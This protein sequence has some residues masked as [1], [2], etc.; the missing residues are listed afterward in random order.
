MIDKSIFNAACIRRAK[1]IFLYFLSFFQLHRF[2]RN[3][4]FDGQNNC[5]FFDMLNMVEQMT[6]ITVHIT[7]AIF[8]FLCN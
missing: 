1:A 6:K 8:L 3:Y 5:L 2:Q 7:V 4:Y